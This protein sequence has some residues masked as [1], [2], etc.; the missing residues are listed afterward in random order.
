MDPD[1]TRRTLIAA[2]FSAL[3]PLS[4]VAKPVRLC[5][6]DPSISDLKA[7][8]TID[9]HAH[10]FNGSDLQV[11]QFLAQTTTDEQS[12][13]R[14]FVAAM[15]G[16]VQRLAWHLAPNAHQERMAMRRYARRLAKCKGANQLRRIADDAFEE[17]YQKG[18]RNLQH[19]AAALSQTRRGVALLASKPAIAPIGAAIQELPSKYQEFENP[20]E[21][22]I[23]GSDPTL[24]GY[25]RFILHNFNYRHVN[26][27]DYFSTFSKD[28]TRK[29]DLVVANLVDFDYWLSKGKAT[30][31]TLSE[32]VD[33]MSEISVM[34]GGRVHGFVPFCPFRELMT[35]DSSGM[36]ESLRLVRR[37]IE[38]RGFIGVKLYPPMGFAAL[39]NME[40]SIWQTKPGLLPA[41][42]KPGFGAQLDASMRRLFRYCV[43]NDVPIMAHSNNSNGPNEEF[44]E[45]ASSVYWGNALKEFPQ[46]RVN[47]GHFGDSDPEDHDGERTQEFLKLMTKQPGAAGQH[48]FGDSGFFA[49]A[50]MNYDK[51][52]DVL[53]HLYAVDK[54]IMRERLMYGSDWL[55]VLIERKADDYLTDFMEVMRRTECAIRRGECEEMRRIKGEEIRR[56]ECETLALAAGQKSLSDAFFGHNAAEFLGLRLGRGNRGRLERFYRRYGMAEPDWMIKLR[57]T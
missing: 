48:A 43:D 52:V 2:I 18:R 49:G 53:T 13:L 55:M 23:L 46:L 19:T 57:T 10:F 6:N 51:M 26:A 1:P 16:V 7:P 32:Q 47:F 31:T 29:V 35:V 24:R 28:S 56:C 14:P 9:T 42:G 3:A 12:E 11:K 34:L 4:A 15:A 22:S 30:A 41:A 8:L 5:V 45:L 17:G 25:L 20:P 40:K 54:G 37:A 39:G 50:L 36:G 21:S 38:Q 27:I 44:R 33:L